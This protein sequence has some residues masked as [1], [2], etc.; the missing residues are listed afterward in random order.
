M[1]QEL[2]VPQV[3]RWVALLCLLTLVLGVENHDLWTPDEP[4]EAA[5]ALEMANGSDWLIP[6]L[7]GVP[8]VEK[9]PLYYWLSGGTI[10]L[11][12][13]LI[14]PTAAA[15]GL[16]ALA[17]AG[18]LVM[19]YLTCRPCLGK[20][21]A[22]AAVLILTT[23]YGLWR[24]AHWIIID[25]LL[26]FFVSSAIFLLFLGL[27]R[28]NLPAI[29]LGY[30]SGAAAFLTK[31]PVAWTLLF[32][33]WLLIY[34]LYRREVKEHIPRHLAGLLLLVGP[35]LA[36]A[37]L[38]RERAGEE[39]WR[40]WFWDNQLGRFLGT[41]THLGNIKGPLYYFWLLPLI[42]LPWTPGLVGWFLGRGWRNLPEYD[43]SQRNLI[44]VSLAWLFGGFLILSLSG[45]KREPYLYPLLPAAAVIAME[46]I[47][48]GPKLV[49]KSLLGLSL[50]YAL[51]LLIFSF[52]SLDWSNNQILARLT[53]Q[54]VAVLAFLIAGLAFA[55]L[56]DRPL[57]L[58]SAITA[59][60]YLSFVLLACPTLNKVWSYRPAVEVLTGA[61]PSGY[62]NRV[63][64]WGSDEAT[65]GSF[66]FYSNLNLTELPD[67]DPE[68]LARILRGGD[69]RYPL[70]VIPR[71]DRFKSEAEN[72]PPWKLLASKRR[73]EHRVFALIAP[74]S[75]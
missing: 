54:P 56:K 40:V 64:V 33:P 44:L 3:P 2:K 45:T 18:C 75:F 25:T 9:P 48:V 58:T 42:L 70:I 13:N 53:I 43:R 50:V 61:I 8:F 57:A 73:G 39:L 34:I 30:L 55:R 69:R 19:L 28:K 12:E 32:Y 23:S 1:S 65:L 47:R 74:R 71:Y 10:L 67:G 63:A 46:G 35:V 17:A 16:S 6:R 26:S 59:L 21:S 68:L 66:S 14:S 72:Y 62:E 49:R 41:S 60:L 27:D 11:S 36:W 7:A 37:W 15:R 31:G 20:K 22:L 29:L 24:G 51:P 52:F 4:R 38:F 5:I